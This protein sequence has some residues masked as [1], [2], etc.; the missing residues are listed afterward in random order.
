MIGGR[1]Y[2]F[3]RALVRVF[4][5]LFYPIRAKGTAYFP[6]EGPV[7]LCANHESLADPV[8]IIC[9]LNRPVRFMA[10]K[11]VM[12]VP[13][14]GWLLRSLGAFGVDRGSGDLAAVRSALNILKEG[15]ALGIFPQGSRSWK[16]GGDFQ[17]GAALIAL[18]SGVPVVPVHI[19]SRARLFRPLRLTFGPAVEL[20]L[21]ENRM[22][23]QAL[24]QA[25]ARIQEAVYALKWDKDC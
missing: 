3:L 4:F 8:A 18:R 17:N 22:N 23:S 21:A 10:K 25:T 12:D 19:H 13:V 1:L 15:H 11:E 5:A 2:A 14:L 6:Q 7:L 24:A 9:A 16:S 20:N